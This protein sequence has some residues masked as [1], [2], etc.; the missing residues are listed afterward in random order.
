M[1][2]YGLS[3]V[4]S[5][6]RPGTMLRAGTKRFLLLLIPALLLLPACGGERKVSDAEKGVPNMVP[7][8]LLLYREA[9]TTFKEWMSVFTPS[10]T[11]GP[12]FSLLS[13]K[14]VR[15]L[16]SY[17]VKSTAGFQ[18]WFDKKADAGKH[19]FAYNFSRL[20]IIDIDVT[21]SNRA[22]I[23]AT[24]LVQS[25]DSQLESVGSFF[26]VRENGS[27]KVPFAESGEYERLWWQ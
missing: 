5:N 23:T 18:R 11:R 21:D 7:N 2:R 25:H 13:A 16:K 14:S 4:G 17:G 8:D 6:L 12:A 9:R 24:F 26:L 20:D 22:V 19:P 10:A 27:W 1:L 3:R 15:T